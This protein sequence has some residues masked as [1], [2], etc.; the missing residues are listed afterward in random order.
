MTSL[1]KA[2]ASLF[3]NIFCFMFGFWLLVSKFH[4]LHDKS[5]F[6]KQVIE[7]LQLD[8]YHFIIWNLFVYAVFGVSL[9]Y[10]TVVIAFYLKKHKPQLATSILTIGGGWSGFM[11]LSGGLAIELINSVV[12]LY[13]QNLDLAIDVWVVG[14]LFA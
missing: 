9:L 11:L 2:R 5:L 12:G 14:S 1:N 8:R 3:I 6:P 4:Y 13:T 10:L 7:M